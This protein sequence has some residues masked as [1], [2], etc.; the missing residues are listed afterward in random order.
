VQPAQAQITLDRE[1]HGEA[2][3][4]SRLNPYGIKRPFSGGIRLVGLPQHAGTTRARET[5]SEGAQA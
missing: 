1:V 4:G 2:I 5:I 3:E